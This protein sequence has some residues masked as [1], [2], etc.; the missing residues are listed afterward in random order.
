MKT[1][2]E[3][4]E[5]LLEHVESENDCMIVTVTKLAEAPLNTKQQSRR[6]SG[7]KSRL[8]F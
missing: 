6:F 4:F 2:K 3:L 7:S 8:P 5:I 1:M